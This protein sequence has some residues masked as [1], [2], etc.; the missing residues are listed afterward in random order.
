MN[1]TIRTA[2]RTDFLERAGWNDADCTPLAGDASARQYERLEKGT[3]KGTQRAILMIASPAE[4]SVTALPVP[5][6]HTGDVQERQYDTLAR[7]AGPGTEKFVSVAGILAGA[8]LSVPEIYASDP[9]N[10]FLLLE[11]FGDSL[12]SSV[13]RGGNGQ[14]QYRHAVDVL[15]ALYQT[16]AGHPS[17]LL[18]DYDRTALLTEAELFVRWYLPFKTGRPASAEPEAALAEIWT[19]ILDPLPSPQ[20]IVH[21]DYHA[22]NLF[23]LPARHGT[24]R[25]GLIDFQDALYGSAAYDLVSLL[26]DAR[27]DVPPESAAALYDYYTDRIRHADGFHR[28]TFDR[29]YAVLGAQRNAK[30]L[31]IFCR[32][33]VRDKK[34]R[35]LRHL[36]RVEAHFRKNLSHPCLKPLKIFLDRYPAGPVL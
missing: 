19:E 31:G 20:C 27:R 34:N 4:A 1:K 28:E 26:E 9:Q 33:A 17:S 15:I 13:I 11:D 2:A 21:R 29:E 12:F 5:E 16:D 6:G 10:G 14:E 35:Y 23:W 36:P 7:L 18:A 3:R 25:V 24:E 32:L 22:E 30:I 8:G